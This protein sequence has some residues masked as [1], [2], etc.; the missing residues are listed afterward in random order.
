MAALDKILAVDSDASLLI[1][2][3]DINADLLEKAAMVQPKLFLEAARIRVQK[4]R[5]RRIYESMLEAKKASLGLR[6]R[7]K[8]AEL[9]EKLTE[10]HI[11]SRILQDEAVTEIAGKLHRAE[12]EE[13]FAKL[14]VE[15][16]RQRRDVLKVI[17]EQRNAEAYLGRV[18]LGRME[19]LEDVRIVRERMKKRYPGKTP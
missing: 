3:L 10:A 18:S 15:A 5:S 7:R 11:T 13:E 14:L 2:A 4:M 17:S 12:E 16:F 8:H 1:D 19:E 9:G 6:I